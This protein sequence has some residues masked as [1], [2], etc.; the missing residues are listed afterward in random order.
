M[1]NRFVSADG[2]WR[3]TVVSLQGS[4]AWYRI[5]RRSHDGGFIHQGDMRTA[6]EVALVLRERAGL[7]LADLREADLCM[8]GRRRLR[9]AAV[10]LR[11]PPDGLMT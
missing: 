4:G 7:S 8:A 10:A 1:G 9:L 11:V 6:S 3:V 2:T 5:G